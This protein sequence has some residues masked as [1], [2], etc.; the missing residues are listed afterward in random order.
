MHHNLNCQDLFV[1]ICD[2]TLFIIVEK[3]VSIEIG[4]IL[5]ATEK[6]TQEGMSFNSPYVLIDQVISFSACRQISAHFVRIIYPRP[7]PRSGQIWRVNRPIH[8]RG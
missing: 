2:S 3:T 8:R 5:E 4:E 7:P 1:F 6:E